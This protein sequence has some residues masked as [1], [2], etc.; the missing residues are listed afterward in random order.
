MTM[1]SRVLVPLILQIPL[2]VASSTLLAEEGHH[3]EAPHAVPQNVW[4]HFINLGILLFILF[5]LLRAPLRDYLVR[6]QDAIREALEKAESAKRTA[7]EKLALYEKRIAQLDEEISTMRR[8]VEVSVKEEANRLVA[9][10]VAAATRLEADTLRLLNDEL[11]RA[12]YAL[13][14]E[15]IDLA[16]QMAERL[17]KENMTDVD[18][19][20]LAE[21]YLQRVAQSTE[22]H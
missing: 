16:I 9:Q 22:I 10:S 20:R 2:L 17:L 19:R 1:F 3:A 21:D 4:F 8:E 14:R 13:R 15:A 12:R 11:G 6:R 5:R 18:Q 7:D